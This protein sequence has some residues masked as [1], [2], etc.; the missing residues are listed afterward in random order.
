MVEKEL[1]TDVLIIGGAGAGLRAA[2]E[3]RMNG[4]EVLLLSKMPAGGTS[5]TLVM[6]G[7]IT[8]RTE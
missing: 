6:A 2:I 5:C 4:A 8:G 1:K 3:A 7:W